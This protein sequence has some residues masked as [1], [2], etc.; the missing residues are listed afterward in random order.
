M[1]SELA[2]R[3]CEPCRGGIPALD[4]AGIAEL[5]PQLDPAWTVVDGHHLARTWRLPDFAS[6]LALANRVGE[7]AEAEGHHPDLGIGWGRLQV[8]LWTHKVNGLTLSDFVLAAKI[9]ELA[10]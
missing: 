9:D 7:L 10:R 1:A 3:H 8:D 6:A 2:A 4:A 5:T